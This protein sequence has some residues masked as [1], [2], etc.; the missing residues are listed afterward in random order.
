MTGRLTI[1]ISAVRSEKNKQLSVLE[2]E[3]QKAMIEYK[4][5]FLISSNTL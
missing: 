3:D 4:M 2:T 1:N 5:L